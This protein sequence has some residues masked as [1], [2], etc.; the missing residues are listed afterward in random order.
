MRSG[1]RAE[2]DASRLSLSPSVSAPSPTTIKAQRVFSLWTT[3]LL[4]PLPPQAES[5]RALAV[6]VLLTLQTWLVEGIAAYTRRRR[7]P[8]GQGVWHDHY[9]ECRA[10]KLG[11]YSAVNNEYV[12]RAHASLIVVPM[13]RSPSACLTALTIS[14]TCACSLFAIPSC[15]QRVVQQLRRRLLRRS[16]R[17]VAVQGLRNRPFADQRRGLELYALS[18][19]TVP[20]LDSPVLLQELRCW[21]N[22]VPRDGAVELQ[23]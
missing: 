6:A 3:W 15:S 19:R 12:S 8:A 18:R 10:C 4:L 16:D 17:V 11:K 23:V 22:H 9:D 2:E 7:C 20:R 21:E 14:S 5:M 13:R 1:S